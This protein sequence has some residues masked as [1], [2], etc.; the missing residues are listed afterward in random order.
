MSHDQ[1]PTDQPAVVTCGLPY[2]NGNL[3]VGHLRSYVAGDLFSRALRRVGQRTAFVCGS[4]MHGT[5]VAVNA[6]EEGV[7]PAEFALQWHEQYEERFPQFNVEFDNYGHTDDE[8]NT[9]TTREFVEHW[10]DNDHVFEKEIQVAYD[11]EADQ[12]LPDRYVEGTCPYCGEKARGDECDEGCQRHLEP[13][14]VE[15]PRS[16][17]TG[18][19]AE[20]R[21]REHKFL[22]LAD[23]Q[24]YL[25]GFL[26]RLEGTE[27]AQSQPREWI[28]GELEDLCITRDM[29]WGID[30][31]GEGE[32]DLVL[33]VWVDAPIEYVSSTKQYTERVGPDEYDWEQVWKVDGEEQ[34]GTEWDESW[35]GESGEIIHL[36]GPDI[37]QH[38]CVFWPAMLRGAGYNEPRA[39]LATGFVGIDGKS[40]STSRGRAVWAK[41]YLDEGFHPD[42]FRYYTTTGSGLENDVDFSWDRFAQ[43]VNGELV[44][45]LGNFCYR[46]LLFAHRNYDGTPDA[47]VSAEAEGRIE[48]AVERFETA[49]A[50]YDVRTLGQVAVDLADFGNEYIQ[51]NE[52]WNLVDDDPERAAQVIRDCVQLAKACAVLAQPVMPGKAADLWAQLGEDG[53]VAEAALDDALAA[54]PADFDE[55][56]ELFTKVEDERI[57]ALNEKLRDRVSTESGGDE[58]ESDT[59]ADTETEHM[60]DL[61]DE[62]ISFEQFQD[63]DMRVGEITAAE[64]IDGA[65]ELVRL[66]VDIGIEQRQ[67]VAGLKQLHDVGELPG[68]RVILLANMEKAELFGYESN[69]MVLAAGDEADLLTTH[70]DASLGERVR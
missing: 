61:A 59:E 69:G 41:E 34:F 29:D 52:P 53:E 12:W 16:V 57:E 36:I 10:I 43:R 18:N 17:R 8:T 38:H 5:P 33:Y 63:I 27:R 28:E 60:E 35:N 11:P 70:E 44:G 1:L 55:P 62:R 42:L 15:D 21:T 22:R 23:F 58:D 30:Y 4:D 26:D 56:E 14:E 3:H 66:D 68:T 7:D 64:P 46:A 31:P 48:E 37:I 40:L 67:V 13:G 32:D 9:A 65:D 6:A 25:Q 19:P 47:D 51:Q 50:E 39:V 45:N 49:V 20:Y 24:E 2:A 54:P